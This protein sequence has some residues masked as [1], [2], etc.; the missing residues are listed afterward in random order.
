MSDNTE[1]HSVANITDIPET[2]VLRVELSGQE[3]A[4]YR[5]PEGIFATHDRCTH[6]R[7]RLSDGYLEGTVI[8]CPLHF[9]RFD[10]RT[11]Q[12]LTTPCKAPVRSYGVRLEGD[13]IYVSLARRPI[14]QPQGAL[15][16]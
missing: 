11:G 9:G 14:E 6:L 16:K 5:T 10:T 1:W 7:G 3:I 12:H 2:G 15:C 8:I 13:R 4:L